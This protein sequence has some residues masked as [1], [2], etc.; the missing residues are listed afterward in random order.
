VKHRSG[1]LGAGVFYRGSLAVMKGVENQNS[2]D[3]RIR[4]SRDQP[5]IQRTVRDLLSRRSSMCGLL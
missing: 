5:K 4:E 2:R 3:E 1:T